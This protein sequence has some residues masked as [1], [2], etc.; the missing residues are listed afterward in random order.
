[1]SGTSKLSTRTGNIKKFEIFQ[2]KNKGTGIDITDAVVDIKYY[3][4]VLS[5]SVSLSAIITESGQTSNENVG[6][7]GVLDGLPV[8]GG[9]PSTIVIDDHDG[10]PLK[11]TN[12]DF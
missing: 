7:K 9:E 1:M 2:A 6:L 4:N 5:N 12:D 8:R 10:N 11:F 3:E